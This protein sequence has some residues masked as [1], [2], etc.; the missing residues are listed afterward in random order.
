M[1]G[2]SRRTEQIE[3]EID[4]A[5]GRQHDRVGKIRALRIEHVLQAEAFQPSPLLLAA[6]QRDHPCPAGQGQLCRHRTDAG[7]GG[8]Y[9]HRLAG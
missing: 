3:H 2:P 1:Q 7:S 8:L 5:A 6:R 4:A 9:Q